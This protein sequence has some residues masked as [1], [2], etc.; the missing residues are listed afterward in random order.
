M[1]RRDLL[2][3]LGLVSMAGVMPSSLLGVWPQLLQGAEMSNRLWIHLYASGGWDPLSFCNPYPNTSLYKGMTGKPMSHYPPSMIDKMGGITFATAL[4]PTAPPSYGNFVNKYYRELLV[5]NGIET[6]TN[7]HAIGSMTNTIGIPIR[8]FPSFV[9]Y[10]VAASLINQKHPALSYLSGGGVGS[11]SNTAGLVSKISLEG[12][13]QI[14]ALSSPELQNTK[15]VWQPNIYAQL[16]SAR[17]QRLLNQINDNHL[18]RQTL[19]QQAAYDAHLTTSETKQLATHFPSQFSN[20]LGEQRIQYIC[21]AMA[22]KLTVGAQM[23]VGG[24]WDSHKNHDVLAA[25]SLAKLFSTLDFLLEEAE[26]QGLRE[27]LNIIVSSDFGRTPYFNRDEG[28]DHWSV[29]SMLFIGPDFAG[30]R[31]INLNTS[32]IRSQPVNLSTFQ[33]DPEGTVVTSKHVF[34]TLRDLTGTVGSALDLKYSLG[35]D[36]IVIPNL[37]RA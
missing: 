12:V 1:K 23:R 17:S 14:A 10:A 13:S 26:R 8:D 29:G 4:N 6:E 34:Q 7:N 25:D 37:F 5:I 18:P 15:L 16:E 24:V 32:D 31:M 2:K 22:A 28:K 3:T 27:R 35:T 20:D 11:A 21:A 19:E 33:P 9:A 36:A 30:N